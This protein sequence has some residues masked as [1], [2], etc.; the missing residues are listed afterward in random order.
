METLAITKFKA[1][2]LALFDEVSQQKKRIVITRHGKPIAEVVPYREEKDAAA[3]EIPL[4]DTVV[5]MG[6]IVSPVAEEEWEASR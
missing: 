3:A 2:C 1:N 6:D 4:K 5:S